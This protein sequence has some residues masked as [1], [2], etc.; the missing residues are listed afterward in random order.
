MK[1]DKYIP[2]GA[3]VVECAQIDLVGKDVLVLKN[4][5]DFL[6]ILGGNLTIYKSQ[7]CYYILS[8]DV[9]HVYRGGNDGT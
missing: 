3:R 1:S 6:W 8:S 5:H 2:P 9:I 7:D 4:W